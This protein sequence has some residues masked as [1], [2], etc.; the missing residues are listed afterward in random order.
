M[1]KIKNNCFEMFIKNISPTQDEEDRIISS[2]KNVSDLL[3]KS[4]LSELIEKTVLTGSYKMNTNIKTIE[5]DE[6]KLD[7]DIALI[8]TKDSFEKPQSVM[9]KVFNILNNEYN[10]KD[11]VERQK[12][13]IGIALSKTHVDI[14]PFKVVNSNVD[15][16]LLISSIDKQKW[17]EANPIGHIE[18]FQSLKRE[19]PNF[20]F[21]V[22]ALKWY[23]KINKPT[24]IKYP[25][26]IAY[27]EFVSRY[28]DNNPNKFEALINIMIKISEHQE[29]YLA[30]PLKPDNNLL[31]RLTENDFLKFKNS[32]KEN[33]NI[34]IESLRKS[35]IN[36]IRKVFGQEFPKCEVYNDDDK[37]VLVDKTK[38][39]T[40][41]GI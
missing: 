32:L 40:S 30:D 3:K 2:H 17:E 6:K 28:Y 11:K 25:K 16:P 24:N 36:G 22:R 20:S 9:D 34:V 29:K 33:T 26:G 21:F 14:V 37:E 38:N 18:H 7:V 10:Y 23:N 35:D 27:N 41:Y 8:L 12:R 39:V 15:Q 31:E 1:N 4:D 13:S 19:M 5:T